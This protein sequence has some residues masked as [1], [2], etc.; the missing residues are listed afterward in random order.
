[1]PAAMHRF[2]LRNMYQENKLYQPRALTLA[3]Q[4]IDITKIKTP[5]F[6][7]STKEDHI[8]PWKSTY[9]GMSMFAGPKRF[10]L[11]GSGHIAG[12]VN[13]PKAEK[14]QYWENAKSPKTADAWFDGASEHAG[15]WWPAWRSWL[16]KF[17]G[18]T[19]AARTPGSKKFKSL[20]PAPGTYVLSRPDE[21][22]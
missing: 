20:G 18:G 19:T 4:E 1:M 22:K 2:Y 15:S 11:A 21:E 9:S 16:K 8:A 3:D 14:Y 17:D 13:P 6:F 5:R 10:C 7:L 12:V